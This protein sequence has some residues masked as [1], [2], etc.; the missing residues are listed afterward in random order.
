MFNISNILKVDKQIK[1]KN[2][3]FIYFFRPLSIFPTYIFFKLNLTPNA[4][5]YSRIF[6]FT[7][8]MSHSF[9]NIEIIPIVFFILVLFFQILDFCDGNLARIYKTE[10][11]YG[12]LIDSIADSV[13]P[14]SHLYLIYFFFPDVISSEESYLVIASLFM[15]F[16][17]AIINNKTTFFN[18]LITDKKQKYLNTS[19]SSKKYFIR[20]LF[21]SFIF[22]KNVF[23]VGFVIVNQ[24]NVIVYLIFIISLL[25]LLDSLRDIKKY[26]KKFKNTKYSKL[27]EF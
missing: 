26:S 9:F 6:G 10:S 3:A 17:S 15:Y 1:I 22:M 11:L 24:I 5:T 7:L 23:I 2:Y 8:L 20:S 4:V 16:I 25:E 14:I 18:Y 19:S 13:L 12:K 21:N 27:R